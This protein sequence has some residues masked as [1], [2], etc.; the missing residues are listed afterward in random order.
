MVENSYPVCTLLTN[1]TRLD[2][3]AH[4]LRLGYLCSHRFAI[5]T[6]LISLSLSLSKKDE[7]K[8]LWPRPPGWE[9]PKLTCK[10]VNHKNCPPWN[11]V[12]RS[13]ELV[14]IVII[15][16]LSW[17]AVVPCKKMKSRSNPGWVLWHLNLP[18]R[19][20]LKATILSITDFPLWPEKPC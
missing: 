18:Q 8:T 6:M 3:S 5:G 4:L 1:F 20:T 15:N 11:L 7:S 19:M 16:E 9:V 2:F 10:S 12:M 17:I 13:R 14:F